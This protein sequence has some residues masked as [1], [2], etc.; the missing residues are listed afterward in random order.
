MT[1]IV[2]AVL[3]V[4]YLVGLH[5]LREALRGISST[6]STK[7]SSAWREGLNRLRNWTVKRPLVGH[8]GVARGYAKRV[9]E[10]APSAYWKNV[11][12][13]V[14]REAGLH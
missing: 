7:P 6:R 14:A 1:W 5:N 13:E 4:F 11:A 10:S 3:I 2:W 12:I 8:M 9:I